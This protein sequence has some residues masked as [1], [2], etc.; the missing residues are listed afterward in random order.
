MQATDHGDPPRHTTA[1]L[2]INVIDVNE[3]DPEFSKLLYSCSFYEDAV[4]GTT[5]SAPILATDRDASGN[6]ITYSLQND[7][8]VF[9]IDPNTGVVS[10]KGELDYEQVTFYDVVV[11]A[12]DS[13]VPTRTSTVLLHVTIIDINDNDPVFDESLVVVSFPEN[14]TVGESE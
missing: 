8:G 11:L 5:C 3:Y 6:V 13:G 4:V 2:I 1:T 14:T 12:T 10:T 9:T 7:D